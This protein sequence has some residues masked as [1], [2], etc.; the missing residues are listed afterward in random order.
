MMPKGTS[1][2]NGIGIILRSQ[3]F[4]SLDTGSTTS[5]RHVFMPK[6]ATDVLLAERR[7]ILVYEHESGKRTRDFRNRVTHVLIVRPD[8]E[9]WLKLVRQTSCHGWMSSSF[10]GTLS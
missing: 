5:S 8:V 6:C 7:S 2:S 10:V 1:A 4:L 3:G 9:L